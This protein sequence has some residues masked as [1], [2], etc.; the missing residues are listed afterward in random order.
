MC[1]GSQASCP[2]AVE[3]TEQAGE[4][5]GPVGAVSCQRTGLWDW[6]L[7]EP[8]AAPTRARSGKVEDLQQLMETG[9]IAAG[10]EVM[11]GSAVMAA[12]EGGEEA[13]VG[14]AAG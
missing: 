3:P 12:G 6:Q 1:L 5:P 11:V 4:T 9:K 8:G 13:V 2:L 14:L 10:W 7:L